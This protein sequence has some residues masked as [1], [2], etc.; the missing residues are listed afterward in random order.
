MEVENKV[1][2]ISREILFWVT[3]LRVT[4]NDPSERKHQFEESLINGGITPKLHETLHVSHTFD[5]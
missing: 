2:S 5:R 4:L 3:T 1:R